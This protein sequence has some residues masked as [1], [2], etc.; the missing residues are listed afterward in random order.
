MNFCPCFAHFLADWDEF[1]YSSPLQNAVK[2]TWFSLKSVQWKTSL[3]AGVYEFLP[4]MSIF[5]ERFRWNL[6]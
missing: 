6:V 3:L 1:W 5:L 4:V 2:H